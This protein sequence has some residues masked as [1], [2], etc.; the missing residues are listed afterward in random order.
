[1]REGPTYKHRVLYVYKRRGYPLE[2]LS[3]YETWRRVRDADGTIG[4]VSETMLSDRRTVLV[5]GKS[6][7]DLLSHP[8]PKAPLLAQMDPGVVARLKACKPQFCEVVADGL[9]GWV[10]RTRIWGVRAGENIQ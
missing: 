5:V 9:T 3:S 1:L 7:A 10:D 2:V 4:W 6:H 8:Y